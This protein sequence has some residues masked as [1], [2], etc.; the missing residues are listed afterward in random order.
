MAEKKT[1][2]ISIGITSITVILCVLCLTVF[3][4]LSLS[5]ALSEQKLAEKRAAASQNYYAAE[6]EAAHVVNKLQSAWKKGEDFGIIIEENE[7]T[8]EGNTFCFDKPIDDVQVLQVTLELQDGF[9][10]RGWKVVATGEW[11]PDESLDVWNG[12]MLFEE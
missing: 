8:V 10:I 7:I 9:E 11:T 12:E 2:K 1:P 6:T 4:V 5:T 3:S